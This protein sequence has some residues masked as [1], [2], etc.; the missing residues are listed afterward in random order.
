MRMFIHCSLR[1]ELIYW[2]QLIPVIS[3]TVKLKN[4]NLKSELSMSLIY[5]NTFD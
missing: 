1:L 4:T 2:F 5:S 3:L